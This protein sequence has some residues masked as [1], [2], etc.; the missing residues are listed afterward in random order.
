[1]S[2]YLLSVE[3]LTGLPSFNPSAKTGGAQIA[4]VAKANKPV[5]GDVE[6]WREG[7]RFG[8]RA[9][10]G[11]KS[12]PNS[13]A[14]ASVSRLWQTEIVRAAVAKATTPQE[15]YTAIEQQQT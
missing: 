12:G 3:V 15:L 1:M 11:D 6:E 13:Q 7:N 4:A 5:A 9:S 8:I 14:L 10:R 2:R